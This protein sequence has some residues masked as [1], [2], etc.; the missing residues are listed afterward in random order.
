MPKNS[1]E[2]TILIP[3]FNE[4]ENI[5]F[6]V[7]SLK[8]F[9]RKWKYRTEV[10][11]V[12]D[13]STDGSRELLEK[14]VK[15]EK[16]FRVVHHE[17]NKG[18]GAALKTGYR[19]SWGTVI[20]TMDADLTHDPDEIKKFMEKIKEGYDIVIGSRYVEGGKMIGVA[21]Y[22]RLISDTSRILI[23]ILFNMP[24]KDV[25]NGFR[26]VRK[27]VV[28]NIDL[29]SD[30]FNILPEMVVKARR[31]GYK[32]T[33]VAMTLKK[34]KYGVSK[35]NPLKDYTKEIVTLFKLRLGLGL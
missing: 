6:L 34:R 14:I 16:K 20:S 1:Q 31:K 10:L 19:N 33:E 13:G 26:A 28:D 9:I 3:I 24:I 30:S 12:N 32:I 18:F 35:M 22:R 4:K 29:K 11:M 15:K 21:W 5:P 8:N 23:R 2:L 17:K 25:T 27:T 7:S